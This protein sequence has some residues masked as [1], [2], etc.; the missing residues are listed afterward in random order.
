MLAGT[1]EL[2]PYEVYN[3]AKQIAFSEFDRN[4]PDKDAHIY[5]TNPTELIKIKN[6]NEL[7][8]KRDKLIQFI[9]KDDLISE[10]LPDNITKDFSS[11]DYDYISNLKQIDRIHVK[12]EY[13]LD[14]KVYHFIPK[15]ANNSVILYHQGH[16]GDFLMGK[17][18]I[19]Y[20]VNNGFNVLAFAMP[21]YGKNTQPIV[22]TDFGKIKLINHNHLIF[23]ETDD[24]TSM[25]FFVE[26]IARSL[27]YLDQE[28]DFEKY[29]MVGLS[30]GGLVTTIYSALDERILESY[31]VAGSYP[32][33]LEATKER[34]GHYEYLNMNFYRIANYL[35]LY[36]MS[37][38][39]NERKFIQIFNE[40]DLCCYEGTWFKTYE[41]DVTKT[42]SNL[43]KGKFLIYLDSTHKEHKISEYA[44]EI[45]ISSIKGLSETD[46]N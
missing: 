33:Y 13:G 36:V 8:Q 29:Y 6:E 12:M 23:L 35:E 14:S 22:E 3:K 21:L 19:E 30:G 43:D 40:F 46:N 39:G 31:S 20:F 17:N 16:S 38:Y 44:L 32:I 1:F 4:Y 18:S 28:Y 15:K 10:R 11:S 42:V 45:I 37:S 2:F 25:K 9:W 5:D 26:P 27:N 24:F 7:F 41:D 34:P